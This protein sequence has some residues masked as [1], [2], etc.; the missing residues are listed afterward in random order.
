[1]KPTFALGLLTLISVVMAQKKIIEPEPQNKTDPLLIRDPSPYKP[2]ELFKCPV[3]NCDTTLG[4]FTCFQHSG[5][6]PVTEINTFFCPYDKI[7][8]LQDDQFA[9]IMSK[10]QHIPVN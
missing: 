3:I 1:M 5:T 2:E 7:C 10:M 6:V 4:E 8:N 9:W